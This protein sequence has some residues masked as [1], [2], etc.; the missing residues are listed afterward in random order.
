MSI[1]FYYFFIFLFWAPTATQKQRFAL[2]CMPNR[3]VLFV[4][5]SYEPVRP[6]YA[7]LAVFGYPAWC[8][9]LNQPKAQT[10]TIPKFRLAC[11]YEL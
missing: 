9:L 1:F 6:A 3:F 4:P 2:R 7:S 11:L 5:S 10:N 8:G